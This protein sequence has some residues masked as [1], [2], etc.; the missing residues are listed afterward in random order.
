VRLSKENIRGISRRTDEVK[1]LL[2]TWEFL[3]SVVDISIDPSSES[4]KLSQQVDGIFICVGPIVGLLNTL[5]ICGSK[6]AVVV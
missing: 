1:V 5:L 3:P 2:D 4:G 6:G